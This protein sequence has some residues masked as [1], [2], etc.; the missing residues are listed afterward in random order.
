M[1]RL[2]TASLAAIVLTV[3]PAQ[4]KV[5]S[6]SATGFVLSYEAEVAADPKAAFDAFVRI[7]E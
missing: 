5:T 6:Q 7:G 3:A 2:L 4:A 1:T